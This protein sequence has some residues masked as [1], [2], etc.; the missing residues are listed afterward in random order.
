MVAQ[1]ANDPEFKGSI[2]LCAPSNPAADILAKRLRKYLT[3]KEMFRLNGCSRTFAEVPNT[4]LPHCFVQN[5]IFSIPPL[6]D[7]LRK[8]VVISTCNDANILVQARATNRDIASLQGHVSEM[9]YPFHCPPRN[10]PCHWL[11]LI[12]DEAAQATEPETL[13]PLTVVAPHSSFNNASKPAFVMAG[14]EHQLS[15][16]TYDRTTPLRV[17]LFERLS[18][19]PPYS[20]HP[21][22]RKRM[23]RNGPSQTIRPPF[24]NLTRNYRSHPAIL[25]MPSALFY[26]NTLIPEA[27]ETDKLLRWN[28]WRGRRWPVLFACNGGMDECED[29]R[30]LGTGW[31]NT[32]EAE[33]A[34]KYAS[35]LVSSGLIARISDICIMS[36]FPTQVRRLRERARDWGLYELNIGPMEAFQGLESCV[37]IICTTRARRRFL[38]NDEAKAMGIV[39]NEKKFNVAI[40]RAKEGL[41]VIGNPWTMSTNV[42]WDAFLRFCYRNRLWEQEI[43]EDNRMNGMKEKKPNDWAPTE[44]DDYGEELKARAIASLEA[45]LVFKEDKQGQGADGKRQTLGAQNMEDQMWQSGL[46]AERAIGPAENGEDVE[47]VSCGPNEDGE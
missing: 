35:D 18:K 27:T 11:A 4:L 16:R 34:L 14:D 42:Y 1:L 31:Y 20:S 15:P 44:R 9:L 2:L 10:I 38:K 45:A 6:P 47:A 25:A 32:W 3:P 29:L 21:L 36:P 41:I 22:A 26:S 28:G 17:S 5:D 46:D 30:N 24:V 13:I 8:K 40:T 12:I 39:D 37:V 19:G 43:R 23:G 7:L 33:K